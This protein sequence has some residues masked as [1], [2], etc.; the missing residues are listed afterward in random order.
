MECLCRYEGEVV[1]KEP[2]GLG[3]MLYTT[4]AEYQGLWENGLR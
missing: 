2:W 4:G 1:N 3:R